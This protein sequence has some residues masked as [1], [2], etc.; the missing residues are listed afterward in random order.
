MGIHLL[1]SQALRRTGSVPSPTRPPSVLT[2]T[3]TVPVAQVHKKTL[4]V[5]PGEPG[6]PHLVG[7]VWAEIPP[8]KGRTSTASKLLEEQVV[9][10]HPADLLYS[11]TT[12]KIPGEAPHLP[13][14][15]GILQPE[16]S[17]GIM[18]HIIMTLASDKNTD[19]VDWSQVDYGLHAHTRST[20]LQVPERYT[21]KTHLPPLTRN[22][23]PLTV[24]PYASTSTKAGAAT[25][26]ISVCGAGAP[27]HRAP[28][29][30]IPKDKLRL[31]INIQLTVHLL[32]MCFDSR[33]Y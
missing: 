2:G 1:P 9:V 3:E 22:A 31:L 13:E 21:G 7:P 5:A 27:T 20:R 4:V 17:L 18:G 6:G 24:G 25:S 8:T 14:T 19:K 28:P 32:S 33:L 23:P 11:G 15:S 10:V 30:G 26:P 12:E 29:R 16:V